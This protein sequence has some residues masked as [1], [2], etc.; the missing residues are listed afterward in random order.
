MAK[1]QPGESVFSF[2]C[3]KAAQLLSAVD[4][5]HRLALMRILMVDEHDVGSLCKQVGLSQSAISQH[6]KRLRDA[7][8]V[9]TRRDGQNIHYS[10]S[11]V[12]AFSL[13][14]ALDGLSDMQ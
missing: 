12:A 14:K 8:L 1:S 2:D 10:T 6:L 9:D 13:I 7:K 3:D 5:I 11:S 4:N